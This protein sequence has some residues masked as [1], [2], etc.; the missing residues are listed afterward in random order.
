ML[1]RSTLKDYMESP[2]SKCIVEKI[3]I[4]IADRILWFINKVPYYRYR[5]NFRVNN[6]DCSV[7]SEY[8]FA[9]DKENMGY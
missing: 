1:T 8:E 9:M 2:M 6:S 4:T 3:E 7:V 5:L